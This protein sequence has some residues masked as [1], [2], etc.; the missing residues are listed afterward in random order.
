MIK[1]GR[2]WTL[3]DMIKASKSMKR[4]SKIIARKRVIKLKRFA[5]TKT[6]ERRALQTLKMQKKKKLAGD[7]DYGELSLSHRLMIMRKL[8][9]VLP[10]LKKM[11]KRMVKVK[12]QQEIARHLG[13]GKK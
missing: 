4:K 11:A 9:K 1:E 2:K 12:R 8:E 6:L 10:R 13:S 3:A 5:D 7:K